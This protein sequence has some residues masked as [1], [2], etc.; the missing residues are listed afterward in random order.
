MAAKTHTFLIPAE[1]TVEKPKLDSVDE[2]VLDDGDIG[3]V[4]TRNILT[5]QNIPPHQQ[6]RPLR[7]S[8]QVTLYL[9]KVCF[10]FQLR[11]T[12]ASSAPSSSEMDASRSG[13]RVLRKSTTTLKRL[14][15]RCSI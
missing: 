1:S 3:P 5:R 15:S 12:E 8:I 4:P 7:S 11:E 9:S 10:V 13:R 6:E 14:C 2:D